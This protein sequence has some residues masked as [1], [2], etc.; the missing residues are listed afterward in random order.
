MP[1]FGLKHKLNNHIKTVHENQKDFQCQICNK[2]F[3]F[4]TDLS[5]HVKLVH[6]NQKYFQ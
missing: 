4:K 1:N 2:S 6:G 5:K 3:G